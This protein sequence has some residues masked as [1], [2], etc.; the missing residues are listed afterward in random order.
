MKGESILACKLMVPVRSLLQDKNWMHLASTAVLNRM[1]SSFLQR[2]EVGGRGK[3]RRKD[4]L[5]WVPQTYDFASFGS[6]EA[7]RKSS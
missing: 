7:V 1:S 3:M 6:N 2:W 4:Q 5:R